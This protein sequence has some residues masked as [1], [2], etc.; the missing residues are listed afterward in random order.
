MANYQSVKNAVIGKNFDID[1]WYGAQCWDGVF[2]VAEKYLNGKRCHCGLTGYAKDVAL[3]RQTNGILSWCT[4]VG[5]NATLSPGDICVWGNCSACPSSHIAFYDH[6]NGQSDVYFLGQ[7][8]GGRNGAFTVAK[9]PVSGIIA[10]F[11]PKAWTQSTQSK[12]TTTGQGIPSGWI[13]QTATFTVTVDA[14]NVRQNA[15]TSAKIVATYKR[16]QSVVYDCYKVIGPYV[17]ISYIGASGKRRFMVCGEAKN[18]VNA[19]PYGTFK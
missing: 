14:I 12:P 6:D 19:R 15:S 3:Q 11:R 8:Q 10:V 13:R 4:D 2:Y 18:G 16:G 17:W 9:I 5:L 1:G 7:N